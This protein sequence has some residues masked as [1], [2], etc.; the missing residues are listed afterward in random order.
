[1]GCD[2]HGRWIWT[3]KELYALAKANPLRLI[4]GYLMAGTPRAFADY[5]R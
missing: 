1:M 4:N 2:E 3:P 5:A